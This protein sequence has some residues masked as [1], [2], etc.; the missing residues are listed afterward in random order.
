MSALQYKPGFNIQESK[1]FTW[2]VFV[3]SLRVVLV[4][5]CVGS[6]VVRF[7]AYWIKSEP[8]N[9]MAF[10]RVR[11]AFANEL[12]AQ[13]NDDTLSFTVSKN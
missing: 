8:E 13:L 5:L 4:Y 6:L 10:P 9:V 12:T 7:D 3:V 1:Y 2:E 11:E